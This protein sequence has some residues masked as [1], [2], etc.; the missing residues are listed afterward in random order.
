MQNNHFFSK[1]K[2]Q[3]LLLL[4]LAV[5]INFNTLFNEYA[6]D[7]QV[8]LTGNQLVQKGLRGIPQLCT[9][10]FFYGFTGEGSGLSGGRYRPVALI[11]F[12]I[13]HQFFGD[14]TFISHSINILLFLLVII[15]LYK[16]LQK[17]IFKEYQPYLAFI[18]CLLFVVHPIHTEVIANVKSRDELIVFLLL[19]TSS[20]ALI[21]HNEESKIG[22]LIA[23]LS[24]F[25]LALLTRE[26]AVPFILIFPLVAY[27]FFNQSIKKSI[28]ISIPLIIVF[29]IY[30]ILRISIVGFSYSNKGDILDVP[31]LYASATEA[32]ATKMF[33]LLKYICLLIFPHPLSSDY[34]YNQIPYIRLA[35]IQFVFPFLVIFGLTLFA[36]F[37]LKKRSIFSFCILYFLMTIFLFSNFV[38]DIGAPLAERLLFQP[39]LAICILFATG[40]LY[41]N[42]NYKKTSTTFLVILVISFS[43]KTIIRNRVWKND[44]TLFFTDVNNAPNSLKTN[45][46]AAKFYILKA[47]SESNAELKNEYFRKAVFYDERALKIDANNR[48]IYLGLGAAYFGLNNYLKAADMWLQSYQMDPSHED[49]KNRLNELSNFLLNEGTKIFQNGNTK[50]AISYYK[51]AIELNT[52]NVEAWYFLGGVYFNLNDTKN[53]IQAWQYVLKLDPNHQFNK[54]AFSIQ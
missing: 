40:F 3:L 18:T 44:E 36:F 19:L 8:V 20:F 38:M 34:S 21:K 47:K 2:N 7:D 37:K 48:Y 32:F 6:L 42:K 12:A 24:C 46:H 9:T 41:L 1:T 52:N 31:F 17:H 53:G 51:K 13:E 33:I 14:N 45:I 26:S 25:F 22:H 30:M 49:E 39:S 23:G 27:F 4:L 29:A 16:L 15:L 50:S 10:D 28:L 35:S 43:A 5:G 54:T 11:I